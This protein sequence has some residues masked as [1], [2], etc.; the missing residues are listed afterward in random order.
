MKFFV[1]CLLLFPFSVSSQKISIDLYAGLANY[2]GDLLSKR[3]S[4]NNSNP[5]FGLGLSYNYSEKISARLFGTYT[6]LQGSDATNTDFNYRNL[7]FKTRILEA[8]ANIQYNFVS[9]SDYIISPYIFAG[10]AI[11]NFNPWTTDISGNK[12][13]LQPLGTEGQGLERYPDKKIYKLTQAAIPFGGG[14]TTE[15]SSEF[16]IGIEINLRKL[17]TDYLDDVSGNY[18]DSSYLANNRSLIS[19]KL[20][21]RGNELINGQNYPPEGAQ[22]GNPK[23]KDW[24]YT[25][26]IRLSYFL[27]SNGNKSKKLGCPSF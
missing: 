16:H 10:V 27:G 13:F 3:L 6:N 24:Y 21:F 22:R 1:F 26:V 25:T 12:Y 19:S 18:A 2:Q 8:Q 15:I 9:T 11:F 23:S 17:F 5:A 7:S 20:A 4:L 14:F